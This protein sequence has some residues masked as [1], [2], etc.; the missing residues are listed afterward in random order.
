[1]RIAVTVAALGAAIAVLFPVFPALCLSALLTG[2]ATGAAS[3]SL[4]R[5]VGRAA[6]GATELKR[7]FSWLAIGPALSNFVGPLAAGLMIDYAGAAAG[8]TTGYR[9]AFL[10]MALLPVATWFWIRAVQDLDPVPP[11][12]GARATRAWDLLRAPMM[13]RLMLVNWCL[14]SCWDVHLF[15]V[16]VIGHERGF[17][18]SVTG[19]ILG[20]FAV[21]AAA[22]R[23]VLP[24]FAA[25][26]RENVVIASAMLATAA[27]FALYPFMTS[28]WAMGAR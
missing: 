5:H 1:M 24:W 25:R 2:G 14:S 22:I 7:V 13:R 15:V 10:L 4:Q 11:A 18:A 12:V 9:A 19:T 28:A 17:N 21:A 8:D 26:L 20:G 3:I 27:V 16:P 6:A 23:V